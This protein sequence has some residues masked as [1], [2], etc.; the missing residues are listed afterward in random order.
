MKLRI[1]LALVPLSAV[2]AIAQSTGPA[3][4]YVPDE[5]TA[6][7]IAE[8][9][10]IPVYGEKKILS[11]RPFK[12]VLDGEIWTVGGTLHCDDGKGGTT[13]HCVGGTAEV[14]ISKKDGRILRMMHYK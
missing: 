3:E 1:A 7:A 5:K 8:A 2:L 9:V 6:V 13:T 4:G 14:R 12:A 10:L 11:E